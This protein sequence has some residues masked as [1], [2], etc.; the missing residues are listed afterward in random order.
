MTIGILAYGSLI[1]NPG[2]EIGPVT[3]RRI[4]GVETPFR[5]EFSRSSRVRDGAPT[6]VP[7]PRG[8]AKVAGVVLVLHDSVNEAAAQDMLYRR[9][10]N[11]VGSGDRYA[12]VDPAN[13][14]GAFLGRLDGFAGLDVVFH[15]ALRANIEEPT[16]ELLARLAIASAAAPSGA[17]DRDGIRY[18]MDAMQSGIVTPLMPEYENEIL[19]LTGGRDLEEARTIALDRSR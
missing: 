2:A 10:R 8:G 7:V 14:D 6:L 18:L 13:P 5:V 15:A 16:H 3:V 4:G 12:D 11:R 1:P 9:E 19:R 17:V